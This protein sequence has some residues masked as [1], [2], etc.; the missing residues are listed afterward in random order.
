MFGVA[1]FVEAD[2]GVTNTSKEWEQVDQPAL[3]VG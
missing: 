3:Q 2:F 1:P